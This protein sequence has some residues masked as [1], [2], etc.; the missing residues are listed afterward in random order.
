MMARITSLAVMPAGRV[1]V[2]VMRMALGFF[3]QRQ[4]VAST[5]STSV[6]PMPKAMAPKAP[7]VAVCESPQTRRMPGWVSPCS[8]PMMC[9]MPVRTSPGPKS[10]TPSSRVERLRFSTMLRI[11]WLARA[12]EPGPVG[13]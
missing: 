2:T 9:T 6:E 4:P 10:V 5:C 3:C 8:G 1:P 11:S 13:T 12:S 7:W